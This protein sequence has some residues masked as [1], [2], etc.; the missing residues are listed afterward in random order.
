MP[1]GWASG[2]WWAEPMSEKEGGD[3]LQDPAEVLFMPFVYFSLGE[4]C[5]FLMRL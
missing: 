5:L 1:P 2:T 3:G 4:I